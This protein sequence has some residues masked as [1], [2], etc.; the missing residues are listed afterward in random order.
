VVSGDTLPT[1][2]AL[3]Q[4]LPDA[5][6]DT[7]RRRLIQVN[8]K[9]GYGGGLLARLLSDTG[10]RLQHVT[11]PLW[12]GPASDLY[13]HAANRQARAVAAAVVGDAAAWNSLERSTDKYL[14]LH[15]VADADAALLLP[16]GAKTRPVY[17]LE[18]LMR[19]LSKPSDA[20][21]CLIPVIDEWTGKTIS[22]LP[23][24]RE[25]LLEALQDYTAAR[26]RAGGRRF[27]R[28]SWTSN[29]HLMKAD[30]AEAIA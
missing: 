8:R 23:P 26:L 7:Q 18:G 12:N 22:T 24:S 15:I 29:L 28:N 25:T 14:H 10:H 21:A 13:D 5:L 19:Y 2:A 4:F 3:P 16:P 30:L 17:D 11:V 27:P 9:K 20:R 6:V 1:P